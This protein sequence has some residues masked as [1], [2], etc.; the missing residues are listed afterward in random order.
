MDTI[1]LP[2]KTG[3]RKT[4]RREMMNYYDSA[5]NDYQ[6]IYGR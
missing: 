5:K 1:N 4:R 2:R 6:G 3:K